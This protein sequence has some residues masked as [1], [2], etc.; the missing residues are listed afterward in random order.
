[1]SDVPPGPPPDPSE[2]PGWGAPPP[3]GPPA[4]GYGQPYGQPAG[5]QPYQQYGYGYGYGGHAEYAGFWIRFAA[6]LVDG[7]IIGIPFSLL[8]G[9]LDDSSSFGP[10]VG[11]SPGYSLAINL[12]S[13]AVT[14][15]YYGLLEGGPTG[16]TLGKRLC[17]I[18]VVDADTGQP[19][20]GTGRAV[21][22]Y[23]MSIVSGWA[24]GLG[25]FWMLWDPRNQTWHDKVA[26]TIVVKAR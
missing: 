4:G 12:L 11:Y 13:T 9:L 21:G 14:A 10:G 6:A 15:V 5:Q 8:S 18:R 1:M 20:V 22:R 19:G 3:P 26:R 7:L 23:L 24:I 25:Y 16:Q 17:N 2:P